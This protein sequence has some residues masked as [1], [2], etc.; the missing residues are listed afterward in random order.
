MKNKYSAVIA[1]GG[2]GTR[3]KEVTN[4]I[5]KP[6]FPILKKGTFQRCCEELKIYG[7]NN[8]FVTLGYKSDKFIEEIK[9]I[10]RDLNLNI[11]FF[12]EKQPLGECGA[13]WE[14]KN[15]LAEE[16]FFIN[17]DLIF[18]IDLERLFA[19]HKRLDSSITLVT[20]TSTHPEDS[21]L[22]ATPNGTRVQKIFSKSKE[23]HFIDGG[24]LG[25]AG[26]SLINK[27]VL[28]II[29]KPDIKKKLLLDW[30]SCN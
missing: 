23:N 7:V 26:I 5:P 18:S 15:F 9:K 1:I 17:G 10:E 4:E 27:E 22:I 12:I 24:F 2:L 13:L 28:N 3:L 19:F 8:I 11:E 30:L 14:I 25:N 20:H 29:D 16:F 21:D 6:L